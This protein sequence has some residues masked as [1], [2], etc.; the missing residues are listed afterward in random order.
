MRRLLILVAALA[1]MTVLS[2]GPAAATSSIT[3][4]DTAVLNPVT[5][6][7]LV[8]GTYSCD[9]TIGGTASIG[10][11]LRQGTHAT[12][13][14]TNVTCPATN[15]PWQISV[16]RGL[17]VAGAGTVYATLTAPGSGNATTTE[18]VLIV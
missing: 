4:N 15:A 7:I 16:P 8:S 11:T 10:V 12:Q 2:V 1:A 18:P 9:A 13:G 5:N 3:V 14:G 6:R 17:I